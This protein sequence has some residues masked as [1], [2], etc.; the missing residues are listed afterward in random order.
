MTVSRPNTRPVRSTIC[1]AG[2]AILLLFAAPR[3]ARAQPR[4]GA[5]TTITTTDTSVTSVCVGANSISAPSTCLG[6]AQTGPLVVNQA[7]TL[8][9]FTPASTVNRLYNVGGTLTWNGSAVAVGG[10]VG[11]GT[12]NTLAVFTGANSIGNSLFSQSGT[13]MTLAGTLVSTVFGA[14]SFSAGAAGDESLTVRNTSAGVANRGVL[15]VGNDTSA[16]TGKLAA[17]ASTFT[18]SGAD[19]ANGVKLEGQGVGGLSL[20]AS[21]AAGI[22]HFFTGTGTVERGQITAAGLFQWS[23]FG[24][25]SFSSGGTGGNVLQVA[26]TTAGAGNF[27]QLQVNSDTVTSQID[28]LASTWTTS[29]SAVQAG[30]RLLGNGVGGISIDASN[31]AGVIRFY[32]VG[33]RRW[34]IN[35]AGDWIGATGQVVDSPATPGISACGTSPTIAGKDYAFGLVTGSTATTSCLVTFGHAMTDA[36]CTANASTAVAVGVVQNPTSVQL[37]YAS[38]TSLIIRVLCRGL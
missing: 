21:N 36:A 24:G 20:S 5:F 38:A 14:N 29:G 37:V 7:I 34:G 22:I 17:N 18:T 33:T 26:N 16:F 30:T 2:C 4:P 15:F 27:G 11:P 31:A 10:A 9:S 19:I 6:G 13:V 1:M 25:H 35:A 8:P 23:T 32:T 12:L 28:T 3:S